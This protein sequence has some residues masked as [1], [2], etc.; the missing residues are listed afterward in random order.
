MKTFVMFLFGL[1]V[2]GCWLM[3]LLQFMLAHHW[4]A[5]GW[6]LAAFAVLLC[7]EWAA[8]RMKL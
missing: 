3:M 8:W 4:R 5:V 2:T 6:L 1:L 7:M